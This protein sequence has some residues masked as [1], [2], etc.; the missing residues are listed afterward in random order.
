MSTTKFTDLFPYILPELNGCSSLQA[1]QHVR[2]AVIDFCCRSKVWSYSDEP[3]T[4]MGGAREYDLLPPSGT[5][6]VEIKAM[7][8]DGTLMQPDPDEYAEPLA[9]GAPSLYRQPSPE[10]F[11]LWP[12]PN[13]EYDI[14]IDMTLAPSRASVGFPSW[15]AER[16]HDA[17]VYLSKSRLML[18][19]GNPWT[20]PQQAAIYRS[21]YETEVSVAMA[22]KSKA[23]SRTALRTTSQH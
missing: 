16:Y 19:P 5:V 18:M 23:F 20:N 13:G 22:D 8:C 4:T 15:I 12:M 21:Q 3:T 10:V 17:I 11:V 2:A 14:T 9:T 1:E 7:Y 6:L